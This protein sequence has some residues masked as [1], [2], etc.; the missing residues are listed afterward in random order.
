MSA[1]AERLAASLHGIG[2]V[3]FGEFTLKDGRRSPFYIDLRVLI[4]HPAVLRE[5]A[6]AMLQRAAGLHYDCIAGLPYAGLPIAVAMA[7]ESGTPLVYPRKEAKD[8]GT[9]KRVE[10]IFRDGE[11]ALVVDDVITSGGAKIEGV[12]PL[13]EAGL[14]VEDVL[15]LVDRTPDGGASLRPHGLTLHAVVR[16]EDLLTPLHGSGKISDTEL[17]AARQFLADEVPRAL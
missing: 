16:V 7:L 11:R 2:A 4:G 10:G 14:T 13:R 15:V 5:V 12:A 9:R 1:L 3:K 17:R 6:A 8:Y